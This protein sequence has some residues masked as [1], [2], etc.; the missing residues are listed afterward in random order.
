[1]SFDQLR[2]HL[3]EALMHMDVGVHRVLHFERFLRILQM[4]LSM[5]TS[6]HHLQLK[7]WVFIKDN[8]RGQLVKTPSQIYFMYQPLRVNLERS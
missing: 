1:M 8:T 2:A 6:V 5:S 3:A 4:V 7:S